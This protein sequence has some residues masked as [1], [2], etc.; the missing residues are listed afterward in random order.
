MRQ[1]ILMVITMFWPLLCVLPVMATVLWP[2]E[3]V[4]FTTVFDH[5]RLSVPGGSGGDTIPPSAPTNVRLGDG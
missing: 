2:H 5:V 4:N 3:P 1:F